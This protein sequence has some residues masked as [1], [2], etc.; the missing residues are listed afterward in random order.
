MANGQET[1]PTFHTGAVVVDEL[2]LYFISDA[3]NRI[4][5]LTFD[6]DGHHR[7][8]KKIAPLFKDVVFREDEGITNN[9]AQKINRY[10]KGSTRQL[11]LQAGTLLSERATDFQKK[12]WQQIGRI[13]YGSTRTYGDIARKLG[14][15]RLARAVG[16]ACHANPVAL[17][18]PCHRVIGAA[19]LG[20]FAG[21]AAIKSK[22]IA[23]ERGFSGAER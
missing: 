17:L 16:Q 6:Q 18:V 8:R 20:G 13:S 3:R 9:V 21:G 11:D 1:I 2:K 10:V 5:H 12:V 14:N 4:V 19:S 7:A 15:F 22:L 23:L